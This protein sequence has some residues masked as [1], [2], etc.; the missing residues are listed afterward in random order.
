M[1]AKR[2]YASLLFVLIIFYPFVSC[3]T[4]NHKNPYFGMEIVHYEK[5]RACFIE[6]GDRQD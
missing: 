3:T 2:K 1:F 6:T 5:S 4:F